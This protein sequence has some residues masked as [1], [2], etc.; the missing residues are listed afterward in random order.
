MKL[1]LN[2]AHQ[3]ALKEFA[4]ICA[5]HMATAL[6]KNLKRRIEVDIP[7]VLAC[8]LKTF[9]NQVGSKKR[10]I[11]IVVQLSGDFIGCFILIFSQAKIESHTTIKKIGGVLIRAYLAILEQFIKVHLIAS[12]KQLVEGNFSKILNTSCSKWKNLST[13]ILMLKSEIKEPS[14]GTSGEFLF[15]FDQDGLKIILDRLENHG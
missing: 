1:L 4:N 12:A 13:R 3:D 15:V 14:S 9:V 8:P 10:A 5:G 7:K 6:S 11:G 2:D